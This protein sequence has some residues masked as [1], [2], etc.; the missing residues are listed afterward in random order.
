MERR[1]IIWVL[2]TTLCLLLYM[3]LQPPAPVPPGNDPNGKAAQ[4]GQATEPAKPL[5]L[6][7]KQWWTLGSMDPK[8]GYHLLVTLTNEGGGVERI[9]MTERDERGRLKYR[10]TD[11]KHG[12]LGYFSTALPDDGPGALV[13]VV[14]HG[15]PAKLAKAPGVADAGLLPGD[16]IVA[17]G[18][19]E[20]DSPESLQKALEKTKPGD[21]V[22]VTV[23]RPD[24]AAAGGNAD[25]ADPAPAAEAGATPEGDAL[26]QAP[27]VARTKLVF[28][29]ELT[30]HPLDLVRLSSDGGEDEV[31]GNLDRLSCLMTLSKVGSRE[32]PVGQNEIPGIPSQYNSI[33]LT[34]SPEA[35]QV[36]TEIEFRLPLDQAP[37]PDAVPVELV[38]RYRLRPANDTTTE[39]YALDLEAEL[40]NKS[41]KPQQM[42]YRLNGPNGMTLEGWWYLTKISP[43]WSGA[44]ARD[45]VFSRPTIGHALHG[46]EAIR[47]RAADYPKDPELPL[48]SSDE[49]EALRSVRY[50]AV[51]GQYFSTGFIPHEEDGPTAT[52]ERASAYLL[53][54]PGDLPKSKYRA[55]NVSYLIDSVPSEAAAGE[56]A[57]P[58]RLRLFAGPKRPDLLAKVNMSPVVEYGWF[59]WVAIPLS[60]VLHV[61]NAMVNNYGISIVLLTLV[62]RM[63]MF[64][65]G[66][67]AAIHAQKMQEIAPELKKL[68]EKYK[69]DLQKRMEAQ[70][71]LQK[72]V[73]FNPLSGCLP[74]FIQIP[75]FIGLYRC[76]SVDI[77]LRQAPLRGVWTWCSNLAAPDQFWEWQHVLPDFIAGRGTGWLG[78]YFNIL[79]VVVVALF[80]IQ[81][82]LFMPPATDEQTEMTQKVMNFM[83]VIM[84]VFF[85]KVPAGLCIYFITSSLWSIA[86]RKLV[87]KTIPKSAVLATATSAGSGT[88]VEGKKGTPVSETIAEKKKRRK[89]PM[90]R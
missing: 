47:R 81:Q 29:A 77:E 25:Q 65:L 31:P 27:K 60:K 28:S 51:D 46:T 39:G 19:Q 52:I 22:D 71:E 59:P 83:T 20:V 84:G 58:Q 16:V 7:A 86:E 21:L 56:A 34:K 38:R 26:K 78:P 50:I 73:G 55:L 80:L 85:F 89:P 61:F 15:T 48:I 24:P 45:V 66:R 35:G 33:W 8:D 53:A 10:R 32:I 75:I 88:V 13:R 64:P 41:D 72:R 37:A 90:K 42:A 82:K 79:P 67:R 3:R 63:M 12:Y 23:M 69:D 62:V 14:G 87:K 1:V 6:A 2:A 17:V 40:V 74:M 76:L 18:E 44:G 54:V 43:N 30:E 68:N 57:K 70:R 49:A 4:A 36:P 11:V 5:A 9:E